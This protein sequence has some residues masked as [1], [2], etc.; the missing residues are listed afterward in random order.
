M[1]YIPDSEIDLIIDRNDHGINICEIKLSQDPYIITKKYADQL[2]I[3]MSAFRTFT[4]TR[5]SIFLTMITTFGVVQNEHGLNL[6]S[7]TVELDALFT[8]S[9]K[10]M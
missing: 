5:K 4:K 9:I 2:R 10:F 7:N 1:E 6:V 8:Q 3:K